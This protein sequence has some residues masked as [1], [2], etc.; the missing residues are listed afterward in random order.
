VAL[1]LLAGE[2]RILVL[3]DPAEGISR[4]RELELDGR[5]AVAVYRNDALQSLTLAAGRRAAC[6]DALIERERVENGYLETGSAQKKT[7]RQADGAVN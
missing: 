2:D 6:G 4:F 5:A 7:K 3:H 1:E